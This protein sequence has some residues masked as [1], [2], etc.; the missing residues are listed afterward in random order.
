M[1]S[2]LGSNH[3]LGQ[4]TELRETHLPVYYT[5]KVMIRMQMSWMKRYMGRGLQVS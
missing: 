3:L 5:V 1:T 2:L 4:L